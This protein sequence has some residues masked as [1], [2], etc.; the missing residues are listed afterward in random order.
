[1]S[2]YARQPSTHG[3][4]VCKRSGKDQL[5]K[6]AAKKLA[7]YMQRRNGTR[8][9]AYVCRGCGKWHVGTRRFA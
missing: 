4:A 1:M 7:K 6:G 2:G 3:V 8:I 5:T 9:E